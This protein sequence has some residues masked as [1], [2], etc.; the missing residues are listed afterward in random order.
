MYAVYSYFM[1]ITSVVM[2]LIMGILLTST[3]FAAETEY[4]D[5]QKSNNLQELNKDTNS[6]DQEDDVGLFDI[7]MNF[8]AILFDE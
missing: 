5:Y 3:V 7:V 8:L 2:Y 6:N 1:K 4:T